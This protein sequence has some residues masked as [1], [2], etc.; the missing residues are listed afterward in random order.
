M[1]H[2]AIVH[3]PLSCCFCSPNQSF[4]LLELSIVLSDDIWV[5]LTYCLLV[6]HE[7]QPVQNMTYNYIHNLLINKL[8]KKK[9]EGQLKYSNMYMIAV[10]IPLFT[11]VIA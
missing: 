7:R 4:H 2:L 10:L 3:K 9:D 11:L 6:R 8:F 1:L 5:V